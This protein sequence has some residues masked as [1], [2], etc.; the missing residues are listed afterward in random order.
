MIYARTVKPL[1][2]DDQGE[3]LHFSWT[4]FIYVYPV[5]GGIDDTSTSHQR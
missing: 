5:C 4:L 2:I 3:V 1:L